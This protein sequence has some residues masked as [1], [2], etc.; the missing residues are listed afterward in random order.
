MPIVTRGA[1]A[2]AKEEFVPETLER[3]LKAVWMAS[4]VIHAGKTE[5]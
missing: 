5:L 1:T 4:M 2:I 3:V